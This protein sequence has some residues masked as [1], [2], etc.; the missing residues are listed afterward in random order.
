MAGGDA[1][2]PT[3]NS[4]QPAFVV[5]NIK[6]LIHILLD[7]EDGQY[8]SW[9]E[10]FH[11]HACA[12][13]VLDHID[14]T[15][16]RPENVD[17]STWNR[18][19]AIVKQW[20]YG[21]ISKDLLQTIMKPGA[22]AR[23][24]WT[25][26]EEIFQDNKHTRVVYLEEQFNT[27]RL[28]N[29]SNMADYC[30]HLKT[31]ADQLANVGNPVSEQKMVLQLISGLSK[32]EYDTI[33]TMI[34][35]ADPLP[36]FT[37]ARSQLLLEE[38]R[39]V[40]QESH[41]QAFVTNLQPAP[42]STPIT[43]PSQS[44]PQNPPSGRGSSRGR[45]RFTNRGGRGRGLG[46][47]SQPRPPSYQQPWT[48]TG[49]PTYHPTYGSWASPPCPYPTATSP[50]HSQAGILGHGPTNRPNSM[51]QQQ[52]FFAP[53]NHTA[54][55]Y[56]QLMSPTELGNAFSTMTIQQPDDNW[57]IDTGA[58]S[59][60][61]R[62][63]EN[64]NIIRCMWLFR[65]KYKENGELE[66][67]KAR[68]VVN[69][70]SQEVGIDCDETF[71]PVVKPATIRTVLSIAMGQQWPIRQLDMKNAFLHGDLKETVFMHQPPGFVNPAAPH[72]VC[73]LRKSLYGL[74][75]APGH[76]TNDLLLISCS[77][78]SRVANAISPSLFINEPPPSVLNMS[79]EVRYT[80]GVQRNESES[81]KGADT[82]RKSI[83]DHLSLYCR[84]T[85]IA[86]LLLYVDD[87]ILTAFSDKLQSD[88][89]IALKT[90]FA[91]TDLGNLSY[92]LGISVTRTPH[93][94]FLSQ[95]KYAEDI[96]Y[97]AKMLNCKPMPTP[98]DSK[99]K[100]SAHDGDPVLDPTLYR[101]LAGALQY[102][103]FTQPDIAYAVQQVCLFMHA[104]WTSHFN[105]LKRVLRYLKG[106]LDHGLH[107]YPSAPTRLVSYTDADWGGCPDT[108]RSTS[109]YCVFL[110]DNLI[111]WS[112]K[113]QATL[114]RSSAEAEY[115]GVANVVAETCWLRN[116]LLEL[117]CSPQK[118][119]LV[120]CD[121]VSAVYLASNPVQHQRTKHIEIDIH[122]VRE[123]VAL[124]HVRVLHVPSSFQYADIFTKGL[125]RQLFLD[126][127]SSLSVRPPPAPTEGA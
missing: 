56:G 62:T 119:T 73:R 98:V 39:R 26:L 118:A 110:G 59:H 12:Y 6:T 70:K 82:L 103:T 42:P 51:P 80:R 52:A 84:G 24:L 47:P 93:Y 55:P 109:G 33:A 1:T 89:I 14:S 28:E 37:K 96:L 100:L 95:R 72:Y 125:P 97:R 2:K 32:G 43:T 31:I 25:R 77:L 38:T 19:D 67:Y 86:Y 18:L 124:G 8:A 57:Y 36:S 90:E 16:Q 123:K 105:A 85:D 106:T 27:A 87:I 76:G 58:T 20:I 91:M 11:I 65:H 113:R 122:F 34:Q 3:S 9:V 40:K 68:L 50:H 23:E 92:F 111:S 15:I 81:T 41:Q 21:T 117:H 104:P 49:A 107:L 121:N 5:S 64:A 126:F 102:L 46:R 63:A 127:R 35:Q 83:S 17:D 108:R 74:K 10:L 66:R 61:T 112:A 99:S 69:G 114:S 22:K 79:F 44:E 4:F 71:S 7:Q 48:L 78:D 53:H 13:N 30:K 101:S 75:Q 54:A 29:F 60:L 94:M 88:I 115:R 116:L 45:G 120:Y